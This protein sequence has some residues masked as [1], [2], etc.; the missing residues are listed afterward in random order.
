MRIRAR[1]WSFGAVVVIAACAGGGGDDPVAGSGGTGGEPAPSCTPG[2]ISCDGDVAITCSADGMVSTQQDCAE[3]GEICS[4]PYGCRVCT[5]GTETCS[6]GVARRCSDTGD[7]WTEFACNDPHQGMSCEPDGCKGPCSPGALV[8][9]NVGCEFFPTVTANSVWRDWFGFAAVVANTSSEPAEIFV[10]RGALD[11]ATATVAGNSAQVIELP[12]VLPLKGQDASPTTIP[13]PPAASVLEDVGAFRLRS[14]RP[15]SVYQF[16]ALRYENSDGAATGCP[17]AG[18]DGCF[19]YTNDASILLP[20]HALT[21]NYTVVG[22]RAMSTMQEFIAVTATKDGTVVEVRPTSAVMS[23]TDFGTLAANDVGTFTLDTGDVLQLFTSGGSGASLSGTQITAT[24]GEPLQVLSGIPAANIPNG[25][26]CSDHIEEI[27]PPVETM[28]QSYIVT[29]PRTP[30]GGTSEPTEMATVRVH[31]VVDDTTISFDPPLAAT[32]VLDQGDVFELPTITSDVQ[33][34]ADQ[35]FSV[36][37]Y[38]HGANDAGDGDPS[39]TVAIP[40]EQ[41]RDRYVFVAPSDYDLNRVNVI[42]PS[43]A[44]ITLDGE[45]VP[46]SAFSAVGAS[47]HSVARLPLDKVDIHTIEG[48]QPFGIMVYGYGAYTSFMYPGGMLLEQI[49]EP[50]PIK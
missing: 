31:A 13:V 49:A 46:S 40:T 43:G 17:S 33:I 47:G 26:C 39:Q 29:M 5:A 36:T 19:S 34:S 16:S 15:V 30:E 9:G 3:S 27:V 48:D 45:A 24:G 35:P 38:M 18:S 50:P 2:E 41:F 25:V 14:T 32:T 21:G 37:Q 12:W 28:G 44:S 20:T 23:G 4:S 11:V 22:Y 6:D 42:A 8:L 1:R 7:A 10:N